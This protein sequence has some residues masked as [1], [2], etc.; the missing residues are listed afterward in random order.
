MKTS[1]SIKE[2]AA[3]MLKVQ[4][5]MKPAVKDSTNPHF[6]SKYADLASVWEACRIPLNTNGITVWQSVEGDIASVAVVTRLVHVSGEW[7]EHG[8]LVIPLQKGTAHEVGSATSYGKRYSLAAAVV[9]MTEED[10]DGNSASLTDITSRGKASDDF[11]GGERPSKEVMPMCPS[12]D[13]N[14]RVIV[15]KYPGLKYYS[16]C[17]KKKFGPSNSPAE[18]PGAAEMAELFTDKVSA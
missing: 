4:A 10:D 14:L 17:C 11:V 16:L 7:V 13:L 8:P 15:S 18:E 3:A 12:C 6:H 5:A 1:E 9:V 2:L